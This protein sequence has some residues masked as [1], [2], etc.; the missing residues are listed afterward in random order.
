MDLTEAEDIKKRWQ[1]YTEKLYK[2]K[3]GGWGGAGITVPA[4]TFSFCDH[5][6]P[7]GTPSSQE[8]TMHPDTGHFMRNTFG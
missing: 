5:R 2:N 6:G 1:E 3:F 8:M 4:V 7:L